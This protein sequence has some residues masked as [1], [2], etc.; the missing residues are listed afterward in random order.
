[1]ALRIGFE[2]LPG[3]GK[4]TAIQ[5]IRLGLERLGHTVSVVPE[6]LIHL[7]E[8]PVPTNLFNLNDRLKGQAISRAFKD[9]V[10][11]DRT[12]VS[13][14]AC[15][16]TLTGHGHELALMSPQFPIDAWAFLARE[17]SPHGR[18]STTK[19]EWPWSLSGFARR[20]E[21]NAIDLIQETN[22][23]VFN[24]RGVVPDLTAQIL[25]LFER[26]PYETEVGVRSLPLMV[27]E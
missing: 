2:G 1:M 3:V 25:Q 14:N 19:Y 10:L 23:P 5:S 15:N 24:W 4:S 13:T 6:T 12:W 20:W 22:Q 18:S 9:F 17:R 7:G 27:D 11:V 26:S 16:V 8:A 21:P